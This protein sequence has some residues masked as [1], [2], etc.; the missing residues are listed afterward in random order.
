MNIAS[1]VQSN[2]LVAEPRLADAFNYHAK[3]IGLETNCHHVGTIQSFDPITQ[4][5]SV[6]INY[7]KSFIKQ[8]N[9]GT[10]SVYTKEY[11]VLQ[12]VP[13]IFPGGAGPM[14]AAFTYPVQAGDECSVYFND[15]DYDNWFIGSS[16]SAP[17]TG[18][19]HSYSD[20]ICFVGIRSL[21]KVLL[22]FDNEAATVRNGLSSVKVYSDKIEQ[23]AGAAKTEFGASVWT[24]DLGPAMNVE[25]SASGTFAIK[26]AMGE[27]VTALLQTL[28]TATAGG[29]PLLADLTILNSFKG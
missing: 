16:N 6:S 9:L 28:Q 8:N 10:P 5:A 17:N 14:G 4:T 29:F 3:K 12:E 2:L 1:P 24:L 21:P 15:R 19:L 25:F 20:P 22:D 7:V 11:P 26:N 23:T 13:V 18:R 27:F